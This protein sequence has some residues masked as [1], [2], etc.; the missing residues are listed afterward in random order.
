MAAQT[1][2]DLARPARML[3]DIRPEGCNGP[4][5]TEPRPTHRNGVSTLCRLLAVAALCVFAAGCATVENESDMPWSTPE[6]WEGSPYIPG[7][8]N[9]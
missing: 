4:A 8:G 5:L 1:M 7:F 3:R 2:K 6:P 9:Q